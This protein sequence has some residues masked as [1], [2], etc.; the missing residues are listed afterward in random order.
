MK[1]IH[2]LP[3]TLIFLYTTQDIKSQNVKVTVPDENEVIQTDSIDLPPSM[4]YPLDSLLSDWKSK[5]YII[6]NKECSTSPLNPSFSDSTYIDRLSRIPAIIE[7]PYN[8]VVRRFI[9]LF[10]TRLRN[11]F[12]YELSASNFYI[13][14]FEEALDAYGLP[15]ELKYIPIIESGLRPSAKSRVGATG[16]WQFMLRTG[17]V[18]GLECNSLVDERRDPIKSSWA[19]A[20]YL[21]D[22]Y[23]IYNDWS[24][25]IAAYNCGP[26]TLNKAIRRAGGEKNYW[27]IYRFLPRETQGYL[28]A[29]IAA[30]YVMNYYCDHNICPMETNIPLN[31]DTVQITKD[32][33]FEQISAVCDI[34]IKEI[35]SLNPEYLRQF[36]PGHIKPYTLVLPQNIIS[37]FIDK[38]DSIYKYDA[39][40]L[41]LRH[42]IIPVNYD[43]ASKRSNSSRSRGRYT[44]YRI[45]NGDSLYTIAKK[46]HV[47]VSQLKKWNRMRS[48][49]IH[50]GKRLRIEK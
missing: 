48:S 29:F 32:L 6:T 44:Y 38:Q 39:D 7:M 31:T 41:F 21:K 36:I 43:K 20:H 5:N 11:N 13:P 28:P 4:T 37:K 2:Y 8:E 1:L 49:S 9:D 16:L 46:Y 3:L 30:N 14:I 47:T 23:A 35:Q 12:A 18:Y 10:C 25:V 34:P 24:L 19:V 40:E 15:L 42:E 50:P 45:K 33:Y 27:K 17:K 22:L 26:G